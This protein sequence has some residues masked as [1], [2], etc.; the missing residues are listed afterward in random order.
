MKK[1]LIVA[2]MLSLV[3]LQQTQIH[4]SYTSEREAQGLSTF[5]EVDRTIFT[6]SKLDSYDFVEDN[7]QSIGT[8]SGSGIDSSQMHTE[9][10]ASH[11]TDDASYSPDASTISFGNSLTKLMQDRLIQGNLQNYLH[12]N[13]IYTIYKIGFIPKM[14]M[15]WEEWHYQYH[16][17][18]IG[19]NV[20][21]WFSNDLDEG[22]PSG[23]QTGSPLLIF[24][25]SR[26]VDNGSF[27][28]DLTA[29]ILKDGNNY[30]FRDSS[31]K[32][33]NNNISSTVKIGFSETLHT[34][35]QN[36]NYYAEEDLYAKATVSLEI[37][38]Y[39]GWVDQNWNPAIQNYNYLNNL[40]NRN[41]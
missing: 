20:Y 24:S 35:F 36:Q 31:K 6:K 1:I 30:Q 18:Y 8:E 25:T 38:V 7:V 9:K 37:K 27:V 17:H 11:E 32:S 41:K 39:G 34:N 19:H 2:P 10:Y 33:F 3:P 28:N 5:S 26:D 29:P 21:A 40:L 22:A 4:N 16:A 15:T 14:N 12:P 13:K 23:Q